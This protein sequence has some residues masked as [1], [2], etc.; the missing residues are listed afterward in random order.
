MRVADDSPLHET[1]FQESVPKSTCSHMEEGEEGEKAHALSL[2]LSLCSR[3]PI[4][5]HRR[6]GEI[7]NLPF[8]DHHGNDYLGVD[9][10][11]TQGHVTHSLRMS[12][13]VTRLQSLS[14]QKVNYR[15]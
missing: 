15:H 10:Y 13:T 5:K 11:M 4:N 6:N 1:E 8:H 3:I 12:R 9:H 2:S 14:P 7:G